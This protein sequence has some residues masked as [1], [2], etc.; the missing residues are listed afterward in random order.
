[1]VVVTTIVI[2]IIIIIIKL[3]L[4]LHAN[5]EREESSRLFSSHILLRSPWERQIDR[6]RTP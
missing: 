5:I 2:I 6:S 3:I 1:M 4:A